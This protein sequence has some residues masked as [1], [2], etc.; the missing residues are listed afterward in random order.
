MPSDLLAHL[1][2]WVY[3]SCSGFNL[4]H[5][6]IRVW[7]SNIAIC[8]CILG[9]NSKHNTISAHFEGELPSIRPN[10]YF[11]DV[12]RQWPLSLLCEELT[13]VVYLGIV[14]GLIHGTHFLF[15]I[16]LHAN[17]HIRFAL[18]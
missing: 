10:C 18:T 9:H 3:Q 2:N 6:R 15:S 14:E 11:I 8:Y 13:R 17:C 1:D 4:E 16:Y 7:E 12:H 5:R